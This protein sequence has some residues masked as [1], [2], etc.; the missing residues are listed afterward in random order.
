MVECNFD[1]VIEPGKQ[2]RNVIADVDRSGL[3]P[4]NETGDYGF[5]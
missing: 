3:Y 1:T 4:N 5:A 2:F